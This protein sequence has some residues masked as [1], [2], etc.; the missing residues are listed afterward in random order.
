VMGQFFRP[1]QAG[2]PLNMLID[3]NM[4]IRYKVEGVIPDVLEGNIEAVLS[5]QD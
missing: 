3:N 5:E 1:T 2:T 4:V